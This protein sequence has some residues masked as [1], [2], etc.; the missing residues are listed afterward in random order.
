MAKSV[1]PDLMSHSA[2]SDLGLQC[3]LRPVCPNTSGYYGNLL[4]QF[5]CLIYRISDHILEMNSHAT[6]VK[7]N[8]HVSTSKI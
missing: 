7:L 2:G 1:D 4:Y 6:E 3:L 5:S 8:I